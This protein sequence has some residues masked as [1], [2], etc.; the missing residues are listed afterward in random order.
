MLRQYGCCL[1]AHHMRLIETGSTFVY[2]M[3]R[4]SQNVA[5]RLNGIRAFPVRLLS[6]LSVA[7]MLR[8]WR[9]CLFLILLDIWQVPKWKWDPGSTSMSKIGLSRKRYYLPKLGHFCL[10]FISIAVW[11]PYI[12]AL[13]IY[14]CTW[15]CSL[16]WVFWGTS[17]H[18]RK[19]RST[20]ALERVLFAQGATE[21]FVCFVKTSSYRETLPDASLCLYLGLGLQCSLLARN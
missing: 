17:S 19:L 14:I 20:L 13:A 11:K 5:F 12:C 10:V 4:L 7:M 16:E 18:M 3:K 9:I 21:W 6:R 8:V 2:K 1:L 15:C